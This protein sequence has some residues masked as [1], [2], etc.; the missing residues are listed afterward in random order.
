MFGDPTMQMWGG[1]SPPI[2][3]DPSIFE[4]VFRKEIGPPPPEPPPFW[5]VVT[6]PAELNGQPFSLLRKGQV[7]GK[8]IGA[9]GQANIPA[10]LGDG[11]AP[12]GQLQVALDADNS[13]PVTIEV[14]DEDPRAPTSIT[15]SC[16]GGVGTNDPIFVRGVL[17]G[18]PAGSVVNV[19]YSHPQT[20]TTETVQATTDAQGRYDTSLVGNPSGTWTMTARYAGND[21]YEPSEGTSCSINNSG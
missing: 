11:S 5:V 15:Q 6:I 10:T 4:A 12:S 20:N 9:G 1:G 18:A 7:I 13:P 19:T 8:A 3:F 21:Q 16:S 2:V 14:K 17:S